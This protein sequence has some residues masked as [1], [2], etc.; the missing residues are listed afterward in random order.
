MIRD[1]PDFE[2]EWGAASGDAFAQDKVSTVSCE[3]GRLPVTFHFEQADRLPGN[4]APLR[5][6]M[7]RRRDPF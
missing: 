1:D 6:D 3:A 7:R 5:R 2:L 4:S